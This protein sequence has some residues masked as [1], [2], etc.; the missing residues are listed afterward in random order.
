MPTRFF[1]YAKFKDGT[2]TL[3]P[4]DIEIE[5]DIPEHLPVDPF[6][7]VMEADTPN[8]ITNFEM[9][10]DVGMAFET[11]T[12]LTI[13]QYE[14]G[15]EYI[16]VYG[17]KT[18]QTTAEAKEKIEKLFR[19]HRYTSGFSF[20]KQGTPTNL[21]KQKSE[22]EQPTILTHSSSVQMDAT[23]SYR[24][25]EFS[26]L[27]PDTS[28]PIKILSPDGRVFEKALGI[29]GVAQGVSNANNRDQINSTCMSALLWPVVAGYFLKTFTTIQ[30]EYVAKLRE[31]FIRYVSAQGSVPAIRVGKTPYGILPVTILSDWKDTTIFP[32]RKY[33]REYL[34]GLINNTWVRFIN[35]VPTVMNKS[36]QISGAEN[37]LNILSMEA[38]SHTYYIRGIRSLFYVTDLIYDVLGERLPNNAPKITYDTPPF[39]RDIRKKSQEEIS[40]RLARAFGI[41]TI[42]INLVSKIHKLWDLLCLGRGITSMNFPLVTSSKD[43]DILDPPYLE[44]MYNDIKDGGER[45]FFKTTVEQIGIPGVQPSSA[46]PL[47]FRLLRYSASLVGQ[48]NIMPEEIFKQ[49][50]YNLQF[51]EKNPDKLK[52]LMLQTLDLSS[53]R[54]DAWVSSLANQRLDYLRKNNDGGLHLGAYGWIENL[55]PKEFEDGISTKKPVRDG[56]YIHAPSYAHAAA[57]AVL[58]NGYLTH[59]NESDKKDLLKINL[60][61][62]RTKH[63]LEIINGIQRMPLSELLG[64]RVE[65]RLHDAGLNYLIDEFRMFF[66]LNK[67]DPIELQDDDQGGG[68]AAI[69]RV[70]PRNLTD[71][72]TVYKNWKRLTDSITASNVEEIMAFM[73]TDMQEGGWGPFYVR[74]KAK[75]ASTEEKIKE[76][77]GSLKPHLNYLL[78]EIDGLSDLCLAESVYQA[79]NGNYL[80][81]SAVMDGLSGDGQIPIPEISNSPTSGPRQLQR[82]VLAL[83]VEALQT[84]TFRNIEDTA[85]ETNPRKVAEPIFGKLCESHMADVSFW[86]DVRDESG[87]IVSTE[88]VGLAE[89]ELAALD[90]LYIQNSELETRLKYYG[91][92]RGYAKFDIRYEKPTSI[93]EDDN[94]NT[95]TK[96][97]TDLQF[98]IKALQETIAQGQ[99]LRYSDFILPQESL[100][101]QILV[102][103]IK[104]VFQRYYD[105]LLLF[106]KTI[107]ELESAK[108]D[109]ETTE[110]A[111][112]NKRTAL[113]N[114]SLFGIEYAVPIGTKENIITSKEELDSRITTTIR[115]LKSR[116]PRYD[117]L[118]QMLSEWKSFYEDHGEEAFLE[119]ICN[120][121]SGDQDNERKY[122]K[123]LDILIGQLRS[124]LNDK[125]FL[126][127]PPFTNPSDFLTKLTSSVSINRKVLKWIEKAAYV[128]PKLKLFDDIVTYNQILESAY[129]SFYYDET[130][131]TKSAETLT[132]A[133]S[134]DKDLTSTVLVL[135]TKAGEPEIFPS[136]PSKKLAG[137]VID[138]WTDKIISETQDTAISFHYDGPSTEAPQSLLMAVS[139]HD[140]HRWNK[141]TILT[142]IQ[143]TFRLAKLR[144]ID[145]RSLK[146]LRQF[147]PL[148]ILNSHGGRDT[149]I[150]LFEREGGGT[151]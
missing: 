24:L 6:Q 149:Y 16:I 113:M 46:D 110:Q 96:S 54:L 67:N 148:M 64:Y 74:I 8:W 75:Y 68:V 126:V 115:E 42:I 89:L 59:S 123:T 43:P 140:S 22:E 52:N 57:A 35:D 33:I 47:L 41:H 120:Q 70:E 98:L 114:A 85:P 131:F 11:E 134:L 28:I 121:L 53:Y 65:R 76:I 80:R 77:I 91:K 105:I 94:N 127:L 135:S 20:I 102:D 40:Q 5:K 37:L 48:M 23:S 84:L 138:E 79:V 129:F 73:A 36:H 144:A 13:P 14:R 112:E 136:D 60:N 141:N 63:A 116:F 107:R 26:A 143:D 142:V 101:Q 51:A 83:V 72:L 132:Q 78:D 39:N 32:D 100:K 95:Q 122:H 61:S 19:S 124:I 62:E 147:L 81:S 90:L 50:L 118:E 17:V 3:D 45:N 21:I 44:Q 2:P 151:S 55:M 117:A 150:N 7:L 111:L 71:G 15:F 18:G 10:K 93:E 97:F 56:G 1:I 145:Y 66:P 103:T 139:P 30:S 106:V 34:A 25:T 108:D 146:E 69:E 12:P 31:H 137:L 9:A 27:D 125:I 109:V 49:S 104:E 4:L 88:R 38:V 29:N 82:V 99:P 86:L 92:T 58:R 130:K 119:S 128:R 133:S 87:N